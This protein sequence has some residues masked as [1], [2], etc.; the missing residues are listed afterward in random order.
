MCQTVEVLKD[1]LKG[2]ESSEIHKCNISISDEISILKD[3]FRD[4]ERRIV[5]LLFF[6]I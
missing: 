5:Y 2:P 1:S 6:Y 3:R 4:S